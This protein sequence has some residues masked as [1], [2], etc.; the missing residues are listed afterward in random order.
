MVRIGFEKGELRFGFEEGLGVVFSN[1][2][3][4]EKVGMMDKER[5]MNGLGATY[6]ADIS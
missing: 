4:V 6:G 3:V 2:K 1:E 5:R